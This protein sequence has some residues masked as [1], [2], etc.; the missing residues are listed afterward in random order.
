ME[1]VDIQPMVQ[2]PIETSTSAQ[3]FMIQFQ[4]D[5]SMVVQQQEQQQQQNQQQQNW[6]SLQQTFHPALQSK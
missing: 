5:P 4:Q 6:S 3:P 1:N 2:S